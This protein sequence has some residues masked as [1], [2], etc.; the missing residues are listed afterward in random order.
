LE[1]RIF[2]GKPSAGEIIHTYKQIKHQI[3]MFRLV[4]SL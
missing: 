1:F 2:M 3:V 4:I